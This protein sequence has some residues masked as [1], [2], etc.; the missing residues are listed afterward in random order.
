MANAEPITRRQ[1]PLEDAEVDA[2]HYDDERGETGG[3]GVGAGKV[4]ARSGD[5]PTA[6]RCCFALSRGQCRAP[7]ETLRASGPYN[8][9]ARCCSYPLRIFTPSARVLALENGQ[10][11]IFK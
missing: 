9:F 7:A 1:L 5:R 4:Q 3:F 10:T 11:A 2:R 8:A 6:P